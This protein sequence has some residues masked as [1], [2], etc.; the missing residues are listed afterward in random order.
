M[1][2]GNLTQNVE[3]LNPT[4][5]LLEFNNCALFSYVSIFYQFFMSIAF[6]IE[7]Y[8][9]LRKFV[10]S[11]RRFVDQLSSGVCPTGVST[12]RYTRTTSPNS[13]VFSTK[14]SSN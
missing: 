7:N 6:K 10:S 9:A 2:T 3:C 5:I 13:V 12:K 1:F 4:L 8:E 14:L 11:D